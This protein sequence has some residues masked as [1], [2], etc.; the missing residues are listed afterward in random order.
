MTYVSVQTK[1]EFWYPLAPSPWHRQTARN[2]RPM[3]YMLVR[4]GCCTTRSFASELSFTRVETPG[5]RQSRENAGCHS[6]PSP[7]TAAS[8]QTLREFI[9]GG[10][11]IGQNSE[12][13]FARLHLQQRSPVHVHCCPSRAMGDCVVPRGSPRSLRDEYDGRDRFVFLD[14]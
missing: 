3:I 6:C 7:T 12:G 4:A 8:W 14:S 2:Q 1:C 13:C 11:A 5:R 9:S 10:V